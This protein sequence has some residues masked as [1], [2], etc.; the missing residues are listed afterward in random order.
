M[1][2]SR[3]MGRPT[4][5]TEEIKEKL[6]SAIKKGAP[7]EIACNASG[8]DYVT[9]LNWRAKAENEKLPDYID[10]FKQL[11]EAEGHTALRWLDIIDKA[12]ADGQWTAASWKLERRHAKYFSQNAAIL[13]MNER[14]AALEK[15]TNIKPE[16]K[17]E[18][19]SDEVSEG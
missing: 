5:F 8:I 4:K 9:L 6:I 2:S 14:L 15:G 1:T 7:Y 10:F 18:G 11:K 17:T 12:M 13:E 3:K 16:T 19:E